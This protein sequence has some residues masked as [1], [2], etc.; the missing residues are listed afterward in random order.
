MESQIK[1]LKLKPPMQ[2]LEYLDFQKSRIQRGSQHHGTI[3]QQ[4]EKQTER[5]GF[6]PFPQGVCWRNCLSYFLQTL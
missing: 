4:M 5:G 1:Y 2:K 6:C 3:G